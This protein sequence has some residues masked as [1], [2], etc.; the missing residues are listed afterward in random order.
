MALK[1]QNLG[2][3]E[4][5]DKSAFDNHFIAYS[6]LDEKEC[7]LLLFYAFVPPVSAPTVLQVTPV[8]GD[9]KVV[10]FAILLGVPPFI[11]TWH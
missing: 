4:D 2:D 7:F 3:L 11:P 1:I 8:V 10:L 5:E 6:L 9:V